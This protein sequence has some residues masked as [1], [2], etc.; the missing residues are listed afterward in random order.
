MKNYAFI[1]G[2]NLNLGVQR[3]I[4]LGNKL[5]Y[6]GWKMDLK[7]FSIYLKEHYKVEKAY[8][9]LGYIKQNE[10]MYQIFRSFGFEIVFKQIVNDGYGNVKGNVDAELVLQA[11]AIDFENY[12]QAVV[13]SG[14]GDFACLVEFL[15]E[16]NKLKILLVP[17]EY[18]YSG[19]LKKVAKSR[20]AFISRLKKKLELKKNSFK[21]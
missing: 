2:Q 16:R 17:N 13:V 4:K 3:D 19:L 10:K 11:A 15:R 5:L 8:L 20:I 12:E 7:R 6:K 9:F 21:R 18:R 1:D 14:D